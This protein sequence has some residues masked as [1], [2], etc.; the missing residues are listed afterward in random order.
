M[1]EPESKDVLS[2]DV[3]TIKKGTDGYLFPFFIF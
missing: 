2:H 3:R 1:G